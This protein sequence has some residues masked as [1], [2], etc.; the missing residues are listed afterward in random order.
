MPSSREIHGNCDAVKLLGDYVD[1]PR[2]AVSWRTRAGPTVRDLKSHQRRAKRACWPRRPTPA[3]GRGPAPPE[4][5][6]TALDDG[7]APPARALAVCAGSAWRLGR[8]SKSAASSAEHPHRL[9][10]V[11]LFWSEVFVL[12]LLYDSGGVCVY[13]NQYVCRRTY[14]PALLCRCVCVCVC[15]FHHRLRARGQCPSLGA[16]PWTRCIA[17]RIADVA[18]ANIV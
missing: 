2:S 5:A 7:R 4:M 11:G 16:R 15:H 6:H 14:A 12:E 3:G 9:R 8:W 18:F 1:D 17:R 13:P 10:F